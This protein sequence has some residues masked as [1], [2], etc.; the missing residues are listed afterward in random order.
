MNVYQFEKIINGFSSLKILHEIIDFN[1]LSRNAWIGIHDEPDNAIEAYILDSYSFLFEDQFH[2]VVGFEWWF[3]VM[4]NDRSMITFHADH[5]EAHRIQEGEMKY[6]LLSTCT[7]FDQDRN[8]TIFLNAQHKSKFERHVEPWPPT[9]AVFSYPARGKM[10][11]Y[12]P[13]YIHGILPGSDKQITLWYNVWS[14][15]PDNLQR[16]GVSRP[17]IERPTYKMKDIKEPVLYLGKTVSLDI[18]VHQ[19]PITLKGPHGAKSMGSLWKVS[20]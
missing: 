16:V 15:K 13:T 20:Q 14:Y 8:P 9:E 7:Y 17:L 11:A 18:D 2:G 5:D 4:D 1:P 19:R 6:P 12:D 3:H 10:V